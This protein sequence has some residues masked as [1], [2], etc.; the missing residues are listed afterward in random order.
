MRQTIFGLL[1]VLAGTLA[2]AGCNTTNGSG[3]AGGNGSGTT[4]DQPAPQ[5]PSNSGQAAP[6]VKPYPAGPYGFSKGSV[7]ENYK[8]DGYANSQKVS[9]S[10]QQIEL[11]DFY[12]PTGNATYDASSPFPVGS[13]KPTIILIDVASVWCGPCNQE[14]GTVLPKKHALYAP[15]GGEF[16][17]NLADGPTPGIAATT[18][19]LYNW[20]LKYKVDFPAI[21]DPTYKLMPLWGEDAYPENIAIDTKT[22]KIIE[23]LPGEAVAGSCGNGN[24][25]WTNADCGGAT[26]SPLSFWVKFESYLDKTRAGCTV[27]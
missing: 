14:A 15:C 8:F 22:M 20:T 5:F 16:F 1:G 4:T 3:G 11:A 19:S 26:C 6:A 12:N 21:I 10:L 13:P 2:L 17:L 9:N 7:V 18:K 27:Q 23:V 25:C 24:E